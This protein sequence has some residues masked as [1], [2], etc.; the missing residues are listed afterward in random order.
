MHGIIKPSQFGNTTDEFDESNDDEI[1]KGRSLIGEIAEDVI[2]NVNALGYC[3]GIPMDGDQFRQG[4]GGHESSILT[5][6]FVEN[7]LTLG[8]V[9]GR[10]LE[11]Q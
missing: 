1:L 2:A 7:V 6:R 11:T 9:F 10:A 5:S 3:K 8:N 4:I